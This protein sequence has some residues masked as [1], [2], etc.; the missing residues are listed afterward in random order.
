MSI[1][2]YQGEH[3]LAS[4]NTL[5]GEFLLPIQPGQPRGA[6]R[7]RVEFEIDQNGIVRVSAVDEKTGGS[8]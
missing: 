6:P 1:K 5:L 7:I 3:Q 4:Q 2:I 8:Q